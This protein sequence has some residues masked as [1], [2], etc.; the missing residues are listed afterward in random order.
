MGRE[1]LDQGRL[2]RELLREGSV[3]T[4]L[5]V[6]ERTESTN[7]DVA[8]A[9]RHGAAEGLVVAAEHQVAGRGRLGRSW[10]TPPRSG[11]AVSALLRPTDVAAGRWPW[12]P[13]LTGVAVVAAVRH[14]TGVPAGLKWPNDVVVG[15]RKLGGILVERIETAS[16][17]VAV[18]GVGLNVSLSAAE[19]PVPEATALSLLGADRVDRTA[20]LGDVLHHL[21][22][23]Y[24]RWRALGGD[25]DHGL[26][27]SYHR[28]CSTIDR[29]VSI[30]L[31][32][33]STLVGRAVGIDRAGRLRVATDRGTRVVGAGDVVHL[34]ERS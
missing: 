12:L 14:R 20:L 22:D 4:R 5:D 7:A 19:L 18:V 10:V 21:G 28:V 24:A 3:W 1:P 27:E 30:A 11:L 33:G 16:G 26:R 32:D 34:R 17:P 23:G 13:L 9:A 31:P 25:A 8:Q 29:L 15:D 2:R 6:R